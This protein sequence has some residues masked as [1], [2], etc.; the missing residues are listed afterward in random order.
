MTT[1]DAPETLDAADRAELAGLNEARLAGAGPAAAEPLARGAAGWFYLALWAFGAGRTAD[2]AGHAARAARLA[3]GHTVYPHAAAHLAE[4]RDAGPAEVYTSPDAFAAYIRGGGNVPLYAAATA[5]LA[6]RYR[7]L[8]PSRLLDVGTGDGRAL[9]PALDAAAEGGAVPVGRVDVLEPS[10]AMRTATEAELARRGVPFRSFGTT[11]QRFAAE[12]GAERW[13]LTQSTFALQSLPPADRR[14]L[15]AWLRPR[16]ER[17]LVV[18]FDSAVP[19]DPLEPEYFAGLLA[20]LARGI[21]EYGDD[22]ALIA[23]GFVLP[24][25]LGPFGADAERTNYE[26]SLPEWT[27]ELR[28]A[29]FEVAEPE[30]LDRYWWSPAYLIEAA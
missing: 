14:E 16:T 6:G 10:E 3:P 22:R 21:A 30:L 18:D 1:H 27:A 4:R 5:A 26:L 11:A 20:R 24:V 17:L 25:V 7:R 15:L 9:L 2:A 13:E 23:R 19:A 29:G 12:N 8:R 28:A